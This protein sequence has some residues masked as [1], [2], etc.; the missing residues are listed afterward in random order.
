[1]KIGKPLTHE[2]SNRRVILML[3]EEQIDQCYE[4]PNVIRELDQPG[5]Q[6]I[7]LPKESDRS[8]GI[9]E[10]N[11]I[12]RGQNLIGNL[13][14]QN[15]YQHDSY[16][17]VTGAQEIFAKHKD[18]VVTKLC[19]LLGAN[20]VEIQE[21]RKLKEGKTYIAKAGVESGLKASIDTKQA[22]VGRGGDINCSFNDSQI[23]GYCSSLQ[24]SFQGGDPNV[25]MA[26][27]YLESHNLSNDFEL[28]NLIELRADRVNP[29][30]SR[31]I[32]Y[33]LTNESE[34]NFQLAAKIF[35]G[36]KI[37]GVIGHNVEFEAQLEYIGTKLARVDK[38]VR[39]N[40]E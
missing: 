14:I 7:L 18:L 15:P 8:L 39:I 1:M 2:P 5:L 19:A 33:S 4:E 37:P 27:Q 32:N 35:Q 16:E 11:I 17:L 31:T 21:V 26:M 29:L 38:T 13:L 3:D 34:S 9:I 22:K 30:L 25:E 23:S 12:S 40:F 20:S 24:D 36:L 28:L 6:V 10:R